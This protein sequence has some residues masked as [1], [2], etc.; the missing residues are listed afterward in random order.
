MNRMKW[1]KILLFFFSL[2][3]IVSCQQPTEPEISAEKIEKKS[4]K[5]IQQKPPEANKKR[6]MLEIANTDFQ[7]HHFE[8]ARATLETLLKNH[9]DSS[10]AE[11]ARILLRKIDSKLLKKIPYQKKEPAPQ[12]AIKKMRILTVPET[13]TTWYKDENTTRF[14]DI[15]SFYLYF[16]KRKNKPPELR[17]RIRYC[18]EKWLHIMSFMAIIDNNRF[19]KPLA[20]F[21]QLRGTTNL[22]ELFDERITPEDHKL[23]KKI[24]QSNK[25][26]IRFQG[27]KGFADIML[28][29]AQKKSMKN[30]L[31]AFK[32][33]QGKL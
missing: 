5:E 33:V 9:P 18:S 6:R 4:P 25:T 21:K 8:S 32:E 11:S 16:G 13:G 31:D 26:T 15:N 28:T 2:T 12:A 19:M 1:S 22:Q 27:Q 23:L 3:L 14:N 20:K 24:I 17:L 10:E 7:N 29:Q 30:V